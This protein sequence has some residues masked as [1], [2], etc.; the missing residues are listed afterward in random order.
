MLPTSYIRN[1][2]NFIHVNEQAVAIHFVARLTYGQGGDDLSVAVPIP[3]P[4]DQLISFVYS[5][6]HKVRAGAGR[7]TFLA[8]G[9]KLLPQLVTLHGSTGVTRESYE[10]I[11]SF[12]IKNWVTSYWVGIAADSWSRRAKSK[13]SALH[14]HT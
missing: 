4:I 8:N 1:T 7:P 14:C 5:P 6:P 2:L 13:G 10:L 3:V 11:E 9:G 12:G